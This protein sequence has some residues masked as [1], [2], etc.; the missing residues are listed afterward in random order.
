[1]ALIIETSLRDTLQA[2]NIA[3]NLELSFEQDG[4]NIFIF[5]STSHFFTFTDEL[6]ELN[7]EFE[8]SLDEQ[9]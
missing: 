8:I 4:S 9:A 7:L 2:I 3:N 5:E 1:M 6:N